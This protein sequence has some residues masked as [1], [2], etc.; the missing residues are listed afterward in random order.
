MGTRKIH[1]DRTKRAM[2]RDHESLERRKR[3]A[4]L[5]SLDAEHRAVHER[6]SV[7]CPYCIND[8]A[9]RASE[10]LGRALDSLARSF[11]H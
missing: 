6:G 10:M 2:S 8:S 11:T 5:A 3:Q 7:V 9:Q 4:W 1:N